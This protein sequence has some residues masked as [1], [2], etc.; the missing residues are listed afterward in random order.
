[1][2]PIKYPGFTLVNHE[3]LQSVILITIPCQ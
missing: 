2:S 1:M 3:L